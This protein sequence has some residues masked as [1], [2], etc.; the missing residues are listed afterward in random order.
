MQPPVIKQYP[1]I[2]QAIHLII[3]YIFIQTLVDFPLALLD[4]FNDTEYLYHPVKKVL[5]GVGSTLFI[6]WWGFRNTGNPLKSVF[7]L[8]KFHPFIFVPLT[9]FLLGIQQLLNVVNTW[10]EKVIPAPGWFWEMFNRIFENDFGFFGA[11]MKVVII[12]PVVEELIFR[13]VIMHGLMRNYSK[14]TAI[15]CSGLLFALF[16]L[17]PWQFPATFMLG[18]LLGWLLIETRNI[19]LAIAG[20][21]INNLLVLLAITFH[22]ELT[23]GFFEKIS[24]FTLNVIAGLVGFSSLMALIYLLY[25]PKPNKKI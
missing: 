5:L 7:P 19:L 18:A 15:F 4:Y 6:L 1:T 13:G 25:I 8:K 10:V 14:A 9:L 2:I 20:H 16:H 12:A 3:L 11:F 17:N 24:A 22:E 23:A 21:A